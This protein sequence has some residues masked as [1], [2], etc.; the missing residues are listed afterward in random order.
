MK[1]ELPY[2][3]AAALVGLIYPAYALL[4]GSGT[5]KL[6]QEQPEKKINVLRSTALYLIA[7]SVVA[8]FPFIIQNDN[9]SD[10]GL[11]FI[12]N[13]FLVIGLI[14][15]SFAG[16]ALFAYMPLSPKTSK[17]IVEQ[18]QRVQ[19]LLPSNIEEYRFTLMVAFV[20]GTCEEIVYRGFLLWFFTGLMPLFPAILLANIPFALAHLTSTGIKNTVQV[21]VLA[22]IFTAAFLLTKSLWLPMLLHIWVDLY[23]VTLAY[24]ARKSITEQ[25]SNSSV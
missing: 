3:I 19:F 1:P 20:A 9:I 7:L 21:F 23:A 10:M 13:P 4:G 12:F 6:L 22:L 11:G 24:R 18:N 15:S 25:G 17:S 5:F 8:V 14:A 16:L 2:I